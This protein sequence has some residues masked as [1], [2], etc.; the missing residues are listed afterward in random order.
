MTA[1]DT[2]WDLLKQ[3][4]SNEDIQDFMMELI[5]SGKN[6]E[7]KGLASLGRIFSDTPGHNFAYQD[8]ILE[9]LLDPT[10][11]YSMT[12][13]KTPT[14]FRAE[15]IDDIDRTGVGAAD[16]RHSRFFSPQRLTAEQYAKYQE[17]NRGV[18]SRVDEYEM[19]VS[20]QDDSVLNIPTKNFYAGLQGVKFDDDAPEV[21]R[22]ADMNDMTIPEAQKAIMAWHDVYMGSV[23]RGKD[24]LM[25]R[26][27]PLRDAGF[28]YVTWPEFASATSYP[29]VASSAFGSIDWGQGHEARRYGSEGRSSI[30]DWWDP[31]RNI[32]MEKLGLDDRF[33]VAMGKHTFFP[34]WASWHIGD[35]DS[36][37]VHV[38]YSGYFPKN[39]NYKYQKVD[40][41][42]F[43]S[44]AN[45]AAKRL[46]LN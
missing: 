1:F 16:F 27:A 22:V 2:S 42:N 33:D 28:D 12:G 7:Y 13:A 4:I 19:P 14:L 43:I 37:P 29:P 3:S 17:M 18:K 40:Y 11:Q 24:Q 39:L 46:G 9:Q 34:Q 15:S 6:Q 35:E 32:M 38:P 5:E 10:N 36:A 20:L 45:L 30:D 44:A 26:V 23:P 41:G 31:A 8:A 21:R 25:E